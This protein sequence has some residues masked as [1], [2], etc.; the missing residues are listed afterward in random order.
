MTIIIWFF[1][2][3][4]SETIQKNIIYLEAVWVLVIEIVIGYFE[5]D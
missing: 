2:V 4:L 1:I 3:T 5:S